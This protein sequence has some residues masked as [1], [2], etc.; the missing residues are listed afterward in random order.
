MMIK[1]AIFFA[2]I[3]VLPNF[4][5]AQAYEIKIKMPG[6]ANKQII[7]GHYF[8]DRMLPDDTV[9]LNAQGI[10]SLKGNEKLPGGMYFLFLPNRRYFD[11]LIDKEQ[12]FEIENDTADFVNQFKSKNSVENELFYDYQKFMISKSQEAEKLRA[13]RKTFVGD[14]TKEAEI[15]NKLNQLQQDVNDKFN[16]VQKQHS[17]SFLA[18]FLKA[19]REVELPAEI[20]D[21]K[22]F[23]WYINHYFDNMPL[24]DE[25]FVRTPFYE[26]KVKT[27]FKLL[28][29]MPADSVIKFV[30][31]VFERTGITKEK[32]KRNEELFRF[33]LI[34]VHNHYAGTEI[35][36]HDAVFVHVAENYYIPKAYWAD[37]EYIN[38][39]KENISKTKSNL[40]GNAAPPLIM[41]KLPADASSINLLLQKSKDIR[42]I[43]F[44]AHIKLI[45]QYSQDQA[46]KDELSKPNLAESAK[47]KSLKK[48]MEME[49]MSPVEKQI[50]DLAYREYVKYFEEFYNDVDKYIDGYP[51]IYELK[52][53]NLVIWYWEPDC[54]HCREE[55][56]VMA[57]FYKKFNQLKFASPEKNLEVYAVYLPRA[58]DDWG[59]FTHSLSGWLEFITKNNMTD[60]LNVWDPYGETNYRQ[61]YNVYSTPTVYLLDADKKI[62]A[63]RIGVEAIRRILFDKYLME[64][65]ETN[66]GKN[67]KPAL[68]ELIKLF[69]TKEE[70]ENLKTVVEGRLEGEHKIMAL[71]LIEK[72][73]PK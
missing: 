25:R 45:K 38:K 26:N 59:K 49:N 70:L 37:A 54:S 39:L 9:Q 31:S 57:A 35:M 16:L 61:T 51:D 30:E 8:S 21:D 44:D 53:D 13:E 7:L 43:G 56:P 12:H 34:T 17:T 46:L 47:E 64:N 33:I 2:F 66:E 58:I 11:L 18:V 60:W 27:F 72:S 15:D 19:T 67:L 71:E 32:G 73:M 42:T 20:A 28:D 3:L 55:T 10:G 63:K 36:G 14:L 68:E 6:F 24:Q 22:K 41:Q 40:I 62:V 48:A 5:H 65:K 50:K 23:F 4:M 69:S 52:A 29:Q 1:K